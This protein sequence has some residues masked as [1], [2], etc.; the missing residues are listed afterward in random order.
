MDIQTAAMAVIALLSPYF[1]KAGESI[2]K[3]AGEKLYEKAG[4]L[5]EAI[6]SKFKGDQT[7]EDALAHAEKEP[8]AQVW[9]EVLRGILIMKMEQD[10]NFAETIRMLIEESRSMI[11]GDIITQSLDISGEAEDVFQIGKVGGGITKKD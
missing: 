1:A 11:G 8:T 7:A 10:H 6:K 9:Q 4:V 2:A 5:Y 3:E